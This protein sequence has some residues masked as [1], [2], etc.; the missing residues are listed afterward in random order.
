MKNIKKGIAMVLAMASIAIVLTGCGAGGDTSALSSAQA[1]V[2]QAKKD[3]DDERT[4]YQDELKKTDVLADVADTIKPVD[5]LIKTYYDV[6]TEEMD[7]MEA[8]E[9]PGTDDRLPTYIFIGHLKSD[10]DS[11]TLRTQLA[12]VASK[13]KGMDSDGAEIEVAT[14]GEY[15]MMGAGQNGSAIVN[16]FSLVMSETKADSPELIFENLRSDL[17]SK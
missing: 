1:A 8:Y 2:V 10:D 16:K 5:N 9:A 13:F 6:S 15:I 14:S 3:A 12:N 17:T 11:S 4:A 7:K